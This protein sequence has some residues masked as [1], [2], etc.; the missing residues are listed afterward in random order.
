[1]RLPIWLT[2]ILKF[3]ERYAN[4]ILW[5]SAWGVILKSWD[6]TE[7]KRYRDGGVLYRSK[8]PAARAWQRFVVNAVC[9][10]GNCMS[11]RSGCVSRKRHHLSLSRW[12]F[13]QRHV[14]D[15]WAS[16]SVIAVAGA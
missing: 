10:S 6:V 16:S 5:M 15:Q 13:H 12:Q 3:C 7:M 8:C 4:A 14:C 9:G 2:T 1:M 11:G